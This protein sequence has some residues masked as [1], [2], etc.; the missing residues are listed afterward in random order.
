MLVVGLFLSFQPFTHS[1]AYFCFHLK[2][3]SYSTFT[4]PDKCTY[5]TSI[6]KLTIVK[7]IVIIFG[8]WWLLFF[9]Q[10]LQI[11]EWS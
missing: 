6:I 3:I 10:A 2:A 7:N 1:Y 8:V 11:E 5:S 9:H 4:L